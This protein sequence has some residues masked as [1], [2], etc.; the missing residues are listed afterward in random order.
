M[1]GRIPQSFIDDLLVRTDIVELIDSRVR[2]KKAGKNYQACCPFH[3]EKSPSFTVSQEKQFYHCF[4][5]GAH[6]NAIG[7]IMEYDGLEFPDAIEELASMQGMQVPREQSIGG[8]ANS[9]PA[10]SK[11]LFELMNQI[12]RFY[13]SNLKS[14]PHAVEYLK[15]RG[16]TGEVVK[17]FN[18][19]YAPSDWDQVRRRFGTSRDH[20]QLLISGGML[21]TRDNGPG[22]YDR[23]RDRIMFPIRDK[24]GRVIGFGG[25]VLGDGTPK[26]LNSPE[27]PIFHKGRELFG[28]YEVKQAHKDPR[29]ILVVEG[30]MD[31][32]ALGQYD[33]DYAVAALG[34]ATTSDHIHTLFRTTAEVVC[35]YDG[36]NAG[37]E[38]AW[39][40]L[41]NAL[42]HLQD[43]RELKFVFL[44]DGED[45]DSLVRQIGKEGF[46]ALLDE[47]QPFADFMFQRLRRDAILLGEAGKHEIAHEA[48]ELIRRVPE[49]FTREGLITRLS[50]MMRWGENKQRIAELFA[51]NTQPKAEVNKPKAIKLTPLRRALALMVQYPAVAAKLPSMPELAGLRVQGIKF[52]L[53]LHQQILAQPGIT[54]GILLEHW[55]GTKEGEI[56][57]QLAMYYPFEE[58]N[59]DQAPDIQRELEDTFFGFTSQVLN[60]R[61]E[62]LQNKER[63]SQAEMQELMMLLREMKTEKRNECGA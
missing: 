47:A 16:L 31:V 17:R 27:T 48:A 3:N 33:I 6:G 56:L 19:G 42:P 24:R 25:R 37:R 41:D 21:I 5:C 40:A 2:L 35:C 12:A 8:S 59:P 23:F 11:D 58:I 44:P 49:G 4:G 9:Q 36:D 18:I 51:R 26:Y 54:T 38:A 10:V 63:P 53:Q 22:S 30:Y 34:T 15:G 7:F 52:L 32:V 61:I 46:E 60:Q 20:E 39:R 55:R 62:E 50:S 29:R 13:E 28:L 1:A 14:A 43:G 45:P 57:A